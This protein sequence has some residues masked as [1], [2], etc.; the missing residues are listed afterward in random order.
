MVPSIIVWLDQ[1]PL[2]PIRL[3]V[4]LYGWD[5]LAK[6]VI[7]HIF[8]GLNIPFVALKGQWRLAGG[9]TAGL[10]S[11]TYRTPAGVPGV[12]PGAEN[13]FFDRLVPRHCR[14]ARAIMTGIPAVSPKGI[15]INKLYF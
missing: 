6:L 2:T 9:F 15:Y 1:L 14:G 8:A 3:S 7:T 13:L 11:P 12:S 4:R 10:R 5:N